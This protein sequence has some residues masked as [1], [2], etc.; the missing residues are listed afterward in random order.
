MVSFFLGV[1]REMSNEF[2]LTDSDPESYE[3]IR[4]FILSLFLQL[5]SREHMKTNTC[6]EIAK[7]KFLF[8]PVNVITMP[9][10]NYEVNRRPIKGDFLS[11]SE[12]MGMISYPALFKWQIFQE[13]GNMVR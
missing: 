2:F 1:T 5:Y 8:R 10:S 6:C 7:T 13:T 3:C 4:V 12:R 11:R 9:T